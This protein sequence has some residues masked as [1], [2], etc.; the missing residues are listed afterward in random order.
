MGAV[1]LLEPFQAVELVLGPGHARSRLTDPR[2]L[3]KDLTRKVSRVNLV[4]KYGLRNKD[5]IY[6]I[7]LIY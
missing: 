3:G 1:C 4:N 6:L 2:G 7:Y 5:L